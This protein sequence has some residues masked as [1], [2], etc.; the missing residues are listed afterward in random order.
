MLTIWMRRP[1][2]IEAVQF[3]GKNFDEIREF[4]KNYFISEDKGSVTIKCGDSSSEYELDVM[5]RWYIVKDDSNADYP[6]SVMDGNSL[7]ARYAPVSRGKVSEIECAF[8]KETMKLLY[9]ND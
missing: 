2:I 9:S 4:T 1:E 6:F 5:P 8:Y 7:N 3:D